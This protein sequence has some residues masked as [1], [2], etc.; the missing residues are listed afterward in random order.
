MAHLFQINTSPGGLPKLPIQTA[1]ISEVDV[2]SDGHNYKGHGGPNAAVC[3]YSLECITTLQTE[4]H[5]VFPGALGENFTITGIDWNKMVAGTQLKVGDEVV[6]EIVSFA[7]PCAKL[8]PFLND[9]WRV[10]DEKL[11][12][13]GRPYCKVLQTGTV[14][15]GD[16]VTILN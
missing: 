14:K 9:I 16:V 3:L 1:F 2:E 8:E 6:L 15:I 4:G 7:T 10:S 5:P 12:G 11:P 13:W